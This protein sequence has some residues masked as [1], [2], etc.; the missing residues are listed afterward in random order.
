M[1]LGLE[2]A[3][4][5]TLTLGQS[6]D[7]VQTTFAQ[8]IEIALS[9]EKPG[10]FAKRTGI[11]DSTIRRY[12]AG[13]MPGVDKLLE[14]ATALDVTL[15]WLA[16][17]RGPMRPG[18]TFSQVPGPD[19]LPEGSVLVPRFEVRAAAGAGSLVLSEEIGSYFAVER[20]WLARSLPSW[21]GTNASVGILEGSGDS[22]EPTIRDGD[23]VMAVRDPPEYAVDRG[24]VFL[25]LHHGQLRIKRLQVDMQSGDITLISDNPR[26]AP[27]PVPKARLEFDLR[28]L[29]Q[30]FFAGGR[31]RS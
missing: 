17:E 20:H 31:L 29:A 14:L 7:M 5:Q 22:M 26:Y 2:S 15:D 13:T 1:L 6:S 8:R 18:Q 23:L 9:G 30:I 11:G 16:A 21:A 12:L 19:S 24:G 27:E 10:S 3:P 25:V 28:V 4:N